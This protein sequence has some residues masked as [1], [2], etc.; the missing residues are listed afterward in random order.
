MA[1]SKP[2][3][4]SVK[5]Q[6]AKFSPPAWPLDDKRTFLLYAAV[7]IVLTLILFS[8][9]L[10]GPNLFI[11]NDI[12][13]DTLTIFYPNLVQNARY[14][15]EVGM[16]GWSFYIGLGTNFYPGYLINP[17]QW[18]FLPMGPESIAYSIAWVQAFVLVATGL[19]FYR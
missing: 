10:F 15:E 16:P 3:S 18:I 9:Y 6:P 8:R 13:S 1:K 11:F 19:V 4:T 17:F 14:F 5:S 2:K 12:G 7:T